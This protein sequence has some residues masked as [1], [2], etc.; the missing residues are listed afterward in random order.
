MSNYISNLKGFKYPDSELIRYF[1]K[2][3]LNIK[4]QKVL[5]LGCNNGNNLALF[6]SYDYE[7]IGVELDAQNVENANF[8]FSNVYGFDKFNF[9]NQDMREFCKNTKDLKSD[10]L[11]IPNVINYI[12]KSDFIKLL[13]NIIQNKLIKSNSDFFIRARS[14]KDH[15]YG[16]GK[17]I[18]DGVFILDGDEYSGEKGIICSCYKEYELVEIL[19]SKLN[20]RDF[21]LITSENLNVKSGVY[22]KDSDIIIYG[23][24]N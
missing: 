22:I 7:V 17:Q 3:H 15:R 16:L 20:L 18:D 4:P 24:I 11:L 10:V 13:E 14:L 6:A 9:I 23:K 2:N 5:E 1:F 21:T 12:T 19:K 8:N